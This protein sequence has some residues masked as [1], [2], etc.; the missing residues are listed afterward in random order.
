YL[1]SVTRSFSIFNYQGG[2]HCMDGSH[3]SSGETLEL[4]LDIT[5]LLSHV[6]GNEPF[7]IFLMVDEKDPENKGNGSLLGFSVLNNMNQE[8]IEFQ[9]PDVPMALLDNDRTFA[10]V[11]VNAAVN[12][13]DFQPTGPIVLSAQNDTSIQFSA[14]GGFQPYSWSLKPF[15]TETESHANYSTS[16][17]TM[18]E[19]TDDNAGFA[20]VPLPFSFPF[21]GQE[22]DT[23]YMHVNG[24]ILF[25]RQDMPYYYLLY[26]ENYMKQIRVISGYMNHDLALHHVGDNISYK[27][28]TDS[29]VFQ[30]RISAI[31]DS[32]T[33]N[34]STTVFPDGR[35]QHHYGQIDAQIALPPV[36][37]LGD[38]ST[39]SSYYSRKNLSIPAE[40]DII[41][42]IPSALPENMSMSNDGLL[43]VE[44]GTTGFSDKITI[45]L[46]DAQRLYREKNITLT[47]GPEIKIRLADSLALL[48]PGTVVPILIEVFNHGNDTINNLLLNVKPT[49]HSCSIIGNDAE[50]INLLPGQS[51]QI[52]D[53]FSLQ[54][55]DTVTRPQIVGVE[56]TGTLEDFVFHNFQDFQVTVPVFSIMPPIVVDG[57]NKRLDPG[58]KA[59]LMFKV[60]NLGN[61]TEGPVRVKVSTDSP[62]VGISGTNVFEME[63][64][65]GLGMFL[66]TPVIQPNVSTPNGTIIRVRLDIFLQETQLLTKEFEL[67][68]G[69][70]PIL[71]CD[72]SKYHN[73]TTSLESDLRDLNISYARSEEIDDEILTY[74]ILFFI[75]GVRYNIYP[76]PHE[77][78]LLVQFMDNG[79][80]IF[81]EG[82][83]Y[84]LQQSQFKDRTHIEVGWDALNIPPDTIIGIIDTP[85]EGFQFDY[86]GP[87]TGILNLLPIEPAI[88]WMVDKNSALNFIAAYDNGNYRSIFSSI[89]YGG[90]QSIQGSDRR[91][92]LRRYLEFL[93][94][95]I[96]PLVANF[97]ADSTF[98]CKGSNVHFEPFCN[99]NPTSFHWT[100]EGGTPS[101]YEG[102]NPAITYET[103][104]Y[105][106]VTLT[107]SDGQTSNTF[108]LN[109]FIMV[110]QCIGIP[111]EKTPALVLYPN[112][113]KEMITIR[114]G[115]LTGYQANV[116]VSDLSGRVVLRQAVAAGLTEIQLPV[117]T[118][119]PGCYLIT[120]TD[121]N[122]RQSAVMIR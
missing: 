80:N 16:D 71:I 48:R 49:S 61:A 72:I 73:Q 17:G 107:V 101:E 3:I 87:Y 12:Q 102:P 28:Y 43:F 20:A 122:H 1:P 109:N 81:S 82:A 112:P 37:G 113:A 66:V 33:I 90:L 19:P 98:I 100:F 23:L 56:A 69:K 63:E 41:R 89:Y 31:E 77:D 60:Y 59:T 11:V 21:F 119:S 95:P 13:V 35:I 18:L 64:L 44:A 53:E 110:D 52:E 111:E 9:S 5:P 103:E 55:S 27:S 34:F 46:T 94:Y 79:G 115:T 75:M 106:G 14:S 99:G 4:G 36:I 42:F 88:P 40:G 96:N 67:E 83:S 50:G 62:F 114:T 10:S 97:K 58:E 8:V 86:S 7:R 76:K 57:N 116:L 38:G 51:V 68:I 54:I 6:R 118:L 47:S 39:K 74:D 70:S 45:Q 108:S 24:Y 121:T 120:F 84:L 117:S 92:L 93:G 104:G 30:W 32:G 65:K 25:D 78:S 2:D 85:A 22:Y 26:D 91:E 15:Y 105:F 29:L